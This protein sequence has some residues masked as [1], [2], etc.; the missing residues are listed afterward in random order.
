VEDITQ[1]ISIFVA[2]AKNNGSISGIIKN[3]LNSQ[4]T[5]NS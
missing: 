4:R 5:K 1:Q 3:N 2:N